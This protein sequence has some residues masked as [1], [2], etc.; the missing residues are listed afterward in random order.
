M[1]PITESKAS[2]SIVHTNDWVCELVNLIDD[3]NEFYE[4]EATAT[5]L[6]T[7]KERGDHANVT[8]YGIM[9]SPKSPLHYDLFQTTEERVAR[10]IIPQYDLV[11]V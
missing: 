8:Q 4:P 9:S 3:F 6:S 11:S 7:K 2:L 1:R 5:D 10:Q